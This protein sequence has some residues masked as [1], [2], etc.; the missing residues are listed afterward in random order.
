VTFDPK[1]LPYS[2]LLDT[3][4]LGREQP[5][6]MYVQGDPQKQTAAR[7]GLRLAEAV[8]FRRK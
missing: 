8:P 2:A 4:T 7:K 6:D 3:W 5:S 1:V